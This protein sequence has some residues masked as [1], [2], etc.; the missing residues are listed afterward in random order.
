MAEL[1]DALASGA[2]DRKVVM[3]QVHSRGPDLDEKSLKGFFL[4]CLCLHNLV[5]K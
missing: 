3:V 2:S 4:M 1:V 5:E